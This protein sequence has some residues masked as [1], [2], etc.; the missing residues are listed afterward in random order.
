MTLL[1]VLLSLLMMLCS[2]S[3]DVSGTGTM[4]IMLYQNG[5]K[6][7]SPDQNVETVTKYIVRGTGPG[8]KTFTRNST[9]ST[10]VMDGLP[11]GHWDLSAGA[12][13]SKS[14]ELANGSISVELDAEQVSFSMGLDRIRGSGSVQLRI[15][16]DSSLTDVKLEI[17]MSDNSGSRVGQTRITP[18]SGSGYTTWTSAQVPDGS[19]F[20]SISLYSGSNLVC[21]TCE[22]VKILADERTT[23]N[24]NL[25]S[26]PEWDA[27]KTSFRLEGLYDVMPSSEQHRVN[28]ISQSNIPDFSDYS[29][30]W[31]LDSVQLQDT[32]TSVVFTPN[33]GTHV[34]SAV[35]TK[36][37]DLSI[38]SVSAKFVSKPQGASGLATFGFSIGKD[39][40]GDY[41][42]ATD[43]DCYVSINS[44][45]GI[46]TLFRVASNT[47]QILDTVKATDLGWEWLGD[48][49][50]LWGNASMSFFSSADEMQ[51][52]SVMHVNSEKRIE[53]ALDGEKEERIESTLDIPLISLSGIENCS[54]FPTSSGAGSFLFFPPSSRALIE[55]TDSSG[56]SSRCGLVLPAG[57][58]SF[59]I[60]EG[61]GSSLVCAGKDSDVLWCAGFDGVGKTTD[62]YSTRMPLG[63]IKQAKFLTENLLL[64]T[65]GDAVVLCSRSDDYYWKSKKNVSTKACDIKVYEFGPY[66]YVLESPDTVA[67]YMANG[68]IIRPWALPDCR[69]RLLT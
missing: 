49:N 66:F 31:F 53:M 38:Q 35:I 19:Y 50:G 63:S 39:V 58:S 45:T 34:L 16:W 27:G 57:V 4:T 29:I 46:M 41:I 47:I 13:S 40:L 61:R 64:V 56:I 32:G 69:F 62:W 51:N 33:T 30:A 18:Q 22:A 24:I 37:S 42:S 67:S 20:I 26:D 25:T 52:I 23:G 3:E 2:C 7:I 12:Y 15:D 8:G 21:G 1:C 54:A 48:V 60:L 28:L 59:A 11:M 43:D 5:V 6:T 55:T 10:V 36:L 14:K 44:Q 65:D 9:S 17:S 68:T